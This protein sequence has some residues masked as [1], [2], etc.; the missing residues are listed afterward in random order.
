[1][2]GN[3]VK[4]LDG[5]YG[6]YVTDGVTNASL[7]KGVEAADLSLEKALE[8]LADR[9]ATAPKPKGRKGQ[10]AASAKKASPKKAAAKKASPKKKK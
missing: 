2:T 8:L 4:L 1:V 7:P 3:E 6:P 10:A 5:R 9:A